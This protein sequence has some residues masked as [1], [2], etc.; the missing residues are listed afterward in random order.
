MKDP[1]KISTI[2]FRPFHATEVRIIFTKYTGTV[3]ATKL[4]IEVNDPSHLICKKVEE[5][6]CKETKK[7]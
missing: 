2:S 4:G 5:K 1:Y 7:K 6:K 3:L